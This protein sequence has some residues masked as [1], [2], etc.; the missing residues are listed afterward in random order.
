MFKAT[1][2]VVNMLL[3]TAHKCCNESFE[4]NVETHFSLQTG[5]W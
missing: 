3:L 2:A 1:F 5:Y 4:T